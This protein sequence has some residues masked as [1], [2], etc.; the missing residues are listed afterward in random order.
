MYFAIA[1]IFTYVGFMRGHEMSFSVTCLANNY[2]FVIN[3]NEEI[4]ILPFFMK[5]TQ[6][7]TLLNF[8]ITCIENLFSFLPIETL[9]I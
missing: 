1:D 4:F 5:Y 3:V 8:I 2:M 9:K 6:C 7:S